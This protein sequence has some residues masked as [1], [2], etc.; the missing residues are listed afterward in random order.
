MNTVK[1]RDEELFVG[2]FHHSLDPKRRLII[3][4][5]WRVLAG[6]PPRLYAFPHPDSK[7]LYLYTLAELNRRLRALREQGGADESAQKAIR[8]MTASADALAIDTQGRVRIKDELLAH[9]EVK[10][11]VVLVGTL[12][13]IEL[14]SEENFDMALPADSGMAEAA[15]YGGY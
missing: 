4:S 9:A 10:S 6:E 15:F 7:C 8:S 13:R 12:T 2:S 5:G 11:R 3:P 14:W 1:E